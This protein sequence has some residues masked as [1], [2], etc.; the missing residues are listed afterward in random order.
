MMLVNFEKTYFRVLYW[1]D[2]AGYWKE[3]V[4]AV[5]VIIWMWLTKDRLLMN[6]YV[7][8]IIKSIVAFMIYFFVLFVAG[9]SKI[10]EATEWIKERLKSYRE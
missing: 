8:F 7:D 10:V 1:N 6:V 3:A 4:G 9:E 5:A 2:I